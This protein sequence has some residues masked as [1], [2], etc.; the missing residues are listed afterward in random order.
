MLRSGRQ[1]SWILCDTSYLD[2]SVGL[3]SN[4]RTTASRHPECLALS[5][6]PLSRLPYRILA[7]LRQIEIEK[8]GRALIGEWSNTRDWLPERRSA[9]KGK[10]GFSLPTRS[11]AEYRAGSGHLPENLESLVTPPFRIFL[12]PAARHR[13]IELLR[14]IGLDK[15]FRGRVSRCTR[16]LRWSGAYSDI[17]SHRVASEKTR[18]SQNG[19]PRFFS[20]L[21]A[22]DTKRHI[23]PTT[24]CPASSRPDS[25][26]EE[27]HAKSPDAV[28][29]FRAARPFG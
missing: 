8:A 20:N 17:G 24:I 19:S 25:G 12:A 3:Q 7:A 15:F 27:P 5:C 26:F 13:A 22:S 14:I 23:F 29:C 4:P 1:R 11:C 2:A 21:L 6:L 16:L 28:V 9:A 10:R 18:V